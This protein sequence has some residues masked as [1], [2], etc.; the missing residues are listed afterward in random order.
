MRVAPVHKTALTEG[1][2]PRRVRLLRLGGLDE[3]RRRQERAKAEPDHED[4]RRPYRNG[5]GL[6]PAPDHL[7]DRAVPPTGS[8]RPEVCDRERSAAWKSGAAAAISVFGKAVM[9]LFKMR[10]HRDRWR[11]CYTASSSMPKQACKICANVC[12]Q[13]SVELFVP[14]ALEQWLVNYQRVER[15]FGLILLIFA[16]VCSA[17]WSNAAT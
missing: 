12:E 3:I 6:R 7:D 5:G 2:L 13:T 9:N 17:P 8:R 16:R 4:L 1:L 15:A 14:L 10:L 11:L